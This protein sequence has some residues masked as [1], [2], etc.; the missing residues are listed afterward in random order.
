MASTLRQKWLTIFC[1]KAQNFAYFR[2]HEFVTISLACVANTYQKCIEKFWT[3][4]FSISN[5]NI[6][7]PIGKSI[8]AVNLTLKIFRAAIANVDIGSLKFIHTLFD[9]YLDYM[10]VKLE[11]NRMVQKYTKFD[12]K[13]EKRKLVF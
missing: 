3:S 13:K 6:T 1:Q 7:C 9:T 11:Q 5:G 8:L 12:V 4:N 2:S 10:Q